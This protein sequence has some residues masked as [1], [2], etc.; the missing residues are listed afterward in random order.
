MPL[1]TLL[2]GADLE[3]GVFSL[4]RRAA[5]AD[6][7]QRSA[8]VCAVAADTARRVRA[9]HPGAVVEHVPNGIDLDGRRPT[10]ADRERA[11]RWRAATVPPGRRVV[12]LVGH[13]K[14]KKGVIDLLEAMITAGTA[15]T[16]HAAMI[17]DVEADLVT[18][19][20]ERGAEAGLSWSL[21]P[22]T[23]RWN[24][25]ARYPAFDLVALPSIHDGMPNVALEA[26]A[27]GIP[28]LASNAGG[29]A[30]LVEDGV[31][32]LTFPAGDERGL[33][34]AVA[35]SS[36]LSDDELAEL[37]RGAAKAAAAFDHRTEVARYRAVLDATGGPR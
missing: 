28:L 26:A 36:A 5:V 25:L 13:L 6:A 24:L 30:D 35:R 37:G 14:C 1:V 2:R 20:D 3:T 33:T 34:G 18:W 16:F 4:R 31:S 9:L 12:G 17:G 10:A 23:D 22:F 32:G 21:E 15:E 11:A 7:V 19:L 8:R 29:L 27:V